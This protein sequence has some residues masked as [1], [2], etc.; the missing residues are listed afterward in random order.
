MGPFNSEAL[1]GLAIEFAL[2]KTIRDTATLLDHVAGPDLGCYSI[3]QSPELPYSKAIQQKVRPLKIAWTT[4]TNS[5]ASVDPECIE[6]VHKAVKLLEELGHEVYQ[7]RPIY[8]QASFSLA[9][10]NIWTANIYK[11]IEGAAGLTGKTPSRDNIEAAIWQCYEY[12]KDLKASALL[13]AINTNGLVSRQVAT[14][15]E[16]YDVLL[17]PTIGTLPAK[18]GELN[19]DNPNISAIEWTEQ[20]FTYAP[21]TNLFN[22]TGQPS[23]SLPLAMSAS[24]LPI[25]LQFTGRFAD[26]LTLLQLGKQLE[27]ATPWIERKPPVHV[28]VEVAEIATK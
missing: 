3:I 8:D 26:E 16:D 14:F 7:A 13:D 21:F 17:S 15:F 20:I 6:A 1:N 11:M 2:T 23:L 10:V 12:G 22:A 27:E 25:G 18:I 5:G 9:T 4:E 24:G 28:S 19:A